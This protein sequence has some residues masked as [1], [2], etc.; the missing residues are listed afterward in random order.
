VPARSL[1]AS[2][3]NATIFRILLSQDKSARF[4]NVDFF[5]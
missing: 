2:S 5:P 4:R 3:K 1:N